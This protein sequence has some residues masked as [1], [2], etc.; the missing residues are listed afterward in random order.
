MTDAGPSRTFGF[1]EKLKALSVPTDN[2]I[3]FYN[4][5]GFAPRMPN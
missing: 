3:R 4:D 2:G 1:P 5:K